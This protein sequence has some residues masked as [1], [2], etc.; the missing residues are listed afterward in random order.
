MPR[1][2]HVDHRGRVKLRV[3]NQGYYGV[4]LGAARNLTFGI[5]LAAMPIYSAFNRLYNSSR[6]VWLPG[7]L[8]YSGCMKRMWLV[9]GRRSPTVQ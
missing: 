9:C 6:R 5:Q 8:P 7:A 3:R 1:A 4:L 2:R